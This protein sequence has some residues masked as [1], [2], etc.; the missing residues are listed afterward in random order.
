MYLLDISSSINCIFG[1][2]R[3]KVLKVFYS[4]T[5]NGPILYFPKEKRVGEC[6]KLWFKISFLL[7]RIYIPCSFTQIQT[8]FTLPLAFP[9]WPWSY[10][11]LFKDR[12]GVQSKSGTHKCQQQM[13]FHQ[14]TCVEKFRWC[15]WG[16]QRRVKRA[17]TREQGPPLAAAEFISIIIA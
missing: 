15:Q 16:A 11:N 10:W 13:S 8:Y 9:G 14:D 12:S 4:F 17:Q 6:L 2:F 5:I 7:W 3:F 1:K